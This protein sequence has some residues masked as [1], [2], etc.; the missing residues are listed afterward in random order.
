MNKL[1]E[2]TC[3]A[4]ILEIF[5]FYLLFP[6]KKLFQLGLATQ[7]EMCYFLAVFCCTSGFV[8]LF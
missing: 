8:G 7:S 4:K 3:F 1:S 2:L 5:T 6:G